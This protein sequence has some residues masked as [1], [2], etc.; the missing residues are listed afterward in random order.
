MKTGGG[1]R[2]GTAVVEQWDDAIH[3]RL[4]KIQKL[5]LQ[6]ILRVVSLL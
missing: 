2:G 4:A 6:A 3:N 1:G 5:I